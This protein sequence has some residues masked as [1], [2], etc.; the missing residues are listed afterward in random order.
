MIDYGYDAPP[1]GYDMSGIPIHSMKHEHYKLDDSPVNLIMS[2]VSNDILLYI[3]ELM[4][5]IL[6]FLLS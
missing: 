2:K 3:F 4:T 6:G 1:Q 5:S